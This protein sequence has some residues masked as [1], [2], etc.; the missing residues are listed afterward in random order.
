MC[1]INTK[2]VL[3]ALYKLFQQ[4]SHMMEPQQYLDVES[5]VVFVR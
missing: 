1:N 3:T 4:R 2:I 5:T